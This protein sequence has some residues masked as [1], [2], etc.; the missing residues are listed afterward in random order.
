MDLHA[1]QIQG[2]FDIPVDHL[3]GVATLADHLNKKD[4]GNN[5]VVVSPDVGGVTRARNLA[6]KLGAPL[7]IIDKGDPP[8][9][10][11]R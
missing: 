8:T 7:A 10:F 3:P 11:P 2:F 1:T 9:T 4:L 6:A 5:A